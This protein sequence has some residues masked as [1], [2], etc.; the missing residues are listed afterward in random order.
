MRLFLP[1][2]LFHFIASISASQNIDSLYTKLISALNYSSVKYSETSGEITP[3]KC[4]TNQLHILSTHFTE[5]TKE[6]Q[7]EISKLLSRP[8]TDASFITPSGL[9]R[10][11]YDNSGMH[12]PGYNLDELALALDSS[13]NFEINKLGYL[14]PPSDDG[15][16]GD[17]LYD[18]YIQ[19]LGI[20]YGYTEFFDQANSPSFMVIDNNYDLHYTKGIDGAKVTVAHEFHH[21]IQV[22]NYKYRSDDSFYYE[23]LSTSMEEFVFDYINDYYDYIPSYYRNTQASFYETNGGGYDLAVWNLFMSEKYGFDLIKKS[24]ENLSD[25]NAME[26]IAV[27]IANAGGSFKE[28]LAEFGIW[29]YFTNNRSKPGEYFE[30]AENYPKVK[31]TLSMPFDS[32]Y[33]SV[34]QI[35]NPSSNIYFQFIDISRGLPDTL[36]TIITNSDY[37]TKSKTS[38]EYSVYNYN[39]NGSNQINEYYYSDLSSS[40]KALFVESA[41]FNNELAAE[42]VTDRVEIDFAF[43]QPFSYGKHTFVFI[44]TAPDVSGRANLNVYTSGMDLVFSAEKNIFATDKIVLRWDGKTDSGKKLPTGIYIYITKAGDTIKKGKL[45][46]Y[47]E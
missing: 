2:L 25:Y 3:V 28:D 17:N 26:S 14:K 20:I 30:E 33:E 47:N 46:I 31:P 4:A 36:V 15:E 9:F 40:N 16:G 41:I 24:L 11:H 43:P 39:A 44:P 23:M 32:N 6:Q 37:R 34:S 42:G 10:I 29:N 35:S 1:I 19:D 45:V 38:F 5:L 18:V 7:N 13:Y 8:E 22:G 12:A 21:A 27:S